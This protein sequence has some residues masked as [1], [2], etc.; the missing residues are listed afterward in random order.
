MN[1]SNYMFVNEPITIIS[2]KK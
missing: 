2:K 1:G